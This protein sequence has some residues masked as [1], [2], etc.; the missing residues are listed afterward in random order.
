MRIKK[1][2][3]TTARYYLL[4]F[5]AVSTAAGVGMVHGSKNDLMKL[6]SR[7]ESATR[8]SPTAQGQGRV[9]H[10]QLVRVF[11]HGDDIYPRSILIRPGKLLVVAENETQSDI[12][13]VVEKLNP[14]RAPDAVARVKTP[15]LGKRN[16]QELTLGAGEYEFYEE[17]Q[18]HLRGKIIV[19]PQTR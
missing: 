1:M 11:V 7:G 18:P 19:D 8:M 10:R 6:R 17:S 4:L 3:P 15:H 13:L 12:S 16:R 5:V 9:E 14:G 2:F